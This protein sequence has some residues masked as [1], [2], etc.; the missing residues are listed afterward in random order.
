MAATDDDAQ[1]VELPTHETRFQPSAE[2]PSHC[3]CL[4]DCVVVYS[5]DDDCDSPQKPAPAVSG[6][7]GSLDIQSLMSL[8][9]GVIDTESTRCV[10]PHLSRCPHGW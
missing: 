7:I 5:H 1:E 4:A 10:S 9:P 6:S 3:G 2:L 8:P